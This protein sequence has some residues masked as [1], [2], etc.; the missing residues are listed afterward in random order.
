M[1]AIQ[2]FKD[3]ILE[4]IP[5]ELP[6]VKPYASNVSH[7]H[8]RVRDELLSDKE[9]V[10]AIKN[11]YIMS[12]L[13]FF[14]YKIMWVVL[15]FF[16][17]ITACGGD[18]AQD[19]KTNEGGIP[20]TA[21]INTDSIRDL[22]LQYYTGLEDIFP[23]QQHVEK[24]K[25]YPVDEAPLDTVFFVF[26]E[27]LKKVVAE[28]DVFGLLD[29]VDKDIKASFGGENGLADFVT[30]WNLDT[31]QPDSLE[32]W[33][34]LESV[35]SQGGVFKNGKKAFYAPYYYA[36]W[37]DAY[38]VYDYGVITGS[39][40][41]MRETPSLNSRIVKTVS[42]NIVTILEEGERQEIGGEVYPWIKVDGLDG[43][44]GYVYGKFI[45][46]PIGFRVGF[47]RKPEGWRMVF[48]VAGD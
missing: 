26:R 1:A 9:K 13:S 33:S 30:I 34:V 29:V 37:P 18:V 35:L 6:P 39:G 23:K 4:G 36:T 12:P 38:E 14:L 15:P 32:I 24:G 20:P 16:I 17:I 31:K 8:K 2:S 40:V 43:T 3:A 47:E 42:Y 10:L 41:R 46:Y 28:K 22:Y 27:S 48:F 5:A 11:A 45:G 7:A 25:L 19:G 44:Q 21:S